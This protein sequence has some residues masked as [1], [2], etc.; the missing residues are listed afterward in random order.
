MSDIYF[1]ELLEDQDC[2]IFIA[3]GNGDIVGFAV[4][5]IKESPFESMTSRKFTY[6]KYFGIIRDSQRN[7][8]GRE[9]FKACVEW[10]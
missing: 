5:E 4:L 6:M 7:G 10:S 9:L 3:K 1:Q 2:E 8:I